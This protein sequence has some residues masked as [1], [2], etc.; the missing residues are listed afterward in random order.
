[1]LPEI[2]THPV[3]RFRF[4][5][6]WEGISFLALVFLAM[7]LKY[8]A[9]MPMPNKILGMSHGVLFVAY[10]LALV[11]VALDARWGA[12]RVLLALL[13]SFIP[14]GTFWFVHR[15]LPKTPATAR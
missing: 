4:I 11:P 6:I 9:G 15:Y 13:A 5:A 10:I 1:M 3:S 12:G 14:G 8:W 2:I 7:P